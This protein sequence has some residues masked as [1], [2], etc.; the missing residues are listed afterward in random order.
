MEWFVNAIMAG[1]LERLGLSGG[2]L[3][4][5]F[6]LMVWLYREER[7]DRRALQSDLKELSE[8]SVEAT[9][10]LREVVIEIRAKL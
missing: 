4:G 6:L 7:R 2:L 9:Q 1:V 8:R 5:G 3:L 10:S